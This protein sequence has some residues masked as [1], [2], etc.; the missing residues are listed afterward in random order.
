MAAKAAA[1]LFR[2]MYGESVDYGA[3]L[4]ISS[5][6]EKIDFMT[7]FV[8]QL[9]ELRCENFPCG[10]NKS[11]PPKG[12]RKPFLESVGADLDT[13]CVYGLASYPSYETEKLPRME[14]SVRHLREGVEAVFENVSVLHIGNLARSGTP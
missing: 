4:N 9:I 2:K 3:F 11:F 13:L 12:S 5:C 10:S 1:S 8:V 7:G 14:L 6:A